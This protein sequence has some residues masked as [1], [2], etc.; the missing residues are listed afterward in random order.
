MKDFGHQHF[1]LLG[2][3]L[4]ETEAIDESQYCSTIIDMLS[5]HNLITPF[6]LPVDY[7]GLNLPLYPKKI[8]H[9]MDISTLRTLQFSGP[10]DF[11]SNCTLIFKNCVTFNGPKSQLAECA[12]VLENY[13]KEL[14]TKYFQRS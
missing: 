2:E 14:Y 3:H 13:F 4:F 10:F 6:L 8:K 7:V 9:P 5:S 12:I 11:Y 1:E